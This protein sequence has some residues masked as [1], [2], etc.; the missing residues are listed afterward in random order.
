[1]SD[2]I[3]LSPSDQEEIV[4]EVGGIPLSAAPEGRN[5]LDFSFRSTVG[6]DTAMFLA[7]SAYALDFDYFPRSAGHTPEWLRQKLA[8]DAADNAN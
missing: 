2:P 6:V 7:A 1:M 3:Q 8:E 5:E 4:R